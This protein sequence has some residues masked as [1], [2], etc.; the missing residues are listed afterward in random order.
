[1]PD[2]H[3]YELLLA[4]DDIEDRRT[5]GFVERMTRT[6][7]DKCFRAQAGRPDTSGQRRSNVISTASCAITI[8]SAATST[9]A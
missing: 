1:M 9:T 7:L 2:R 8:L 6:M 4:M 5:N 3:T